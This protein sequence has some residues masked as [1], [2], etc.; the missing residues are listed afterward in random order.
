[1]AVDRMSFVNARSYMTVTVYPA[2]T[3]VI[4]CD[5]YVVLTYIQ[6]VVLLEGENICAYN[7][8]FEIEKKNQSKI[9]R[10][11][12][13]RSPIHNSKYAYPA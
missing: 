4:G 9:P 12:Y 6:L 13:R 11:L 10:R 3:S 1:M 2:A 7:S 8:P 5:N